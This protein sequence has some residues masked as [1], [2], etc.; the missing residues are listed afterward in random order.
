MTPSTIQR[1]GE[2][3]CGDLLITR[4][5]SERQEYT[6]STIPGPAQ[7]RYRTYDQALA[8]ASAWAAQ[9]GVGLWFTDDGTSFKPITVESGTYP[10][11]ERRVTLV[12]RGRH[13]ERSR[14]PRLPR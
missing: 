10:A 9:H 12:R 14:A 4:D 8:S 7:L 11:V 3:P 2:P 6:L 5:R 13:H 1:T